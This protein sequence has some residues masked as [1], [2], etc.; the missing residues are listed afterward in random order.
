[1]CACLLQI[2]GVILSSPSKHASPLKAILTETPGNTRRV[3]S[4]SAMDGTVDRRLKKEAG[5]QPHLTSDARTDL[6]EPLNNS[7]QLGKI[8][9]ATPPLHYNRSS[10]THAR[11]SSPGK[12]NTVED[13][14]VATGTGT[15]LGLPVTKPSNV[16]EIPQ[17]SALR[18]GLLSSSMNPCEARLAQLHVITLHFVLWK[19]TFCCYYAKTSQFYFFNQKDN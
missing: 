7:G 10:S 13:R 2:S 8:T 14:L 17:R 19:F 9:A 18:V 6:L 16:Q 3:A 4:E 5:L 1:M 15:T 12:M 11:E